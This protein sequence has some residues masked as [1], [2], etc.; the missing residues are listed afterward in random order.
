MRRN[1]SVQAL[2][3]FTVF[4]SMFVSIISATLS[5]KLRNDQIRAQQQSQQQLL[6]AAQLHQQAAMRAI[7]QAR[8]PVKTSQ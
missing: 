5:I 1:V 2:V 3:L 4:T 7:H 6:H 8:Q